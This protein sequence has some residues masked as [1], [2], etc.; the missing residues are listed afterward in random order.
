MNTEFEIEL[1]EKI[2]KADTAKAAVLACVLIGTPNQ[3]AFAQD[4]R[5]RYTDSL[6]TQI[7]TPRSDEEHAIMV[8]Y[9]T[10]GARA[11]A[12]WWIDNK[13]SGIDIRMAMHMPG[14]PRKNTFRGDAEIY[15]VADEQFSY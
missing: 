15:G 12:K 13:G 10:T 2:A 5:T 11:L 8:S 3:V 1:L 6:I 4:I 7:N 14:Y 9:L